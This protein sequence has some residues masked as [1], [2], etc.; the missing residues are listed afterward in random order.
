[1]L[2][3]VGFGVLGLKWLKEILRTA[4]YTILLPPPPAPGIAYPPA[5][6]M[7]A[8]VAEPVEA[9]LARYEKMLAAKAPAAL[10]ALQ[11]AL[12]DAQIDAVES[13]HGFKLTP[14]LRALYRWHNGERASAT[15]VFPDHRFVPLDEAAAARDAVRQQVIGLIVDAAGDGYYYDPSRTEAQGSFFFNFAEDGAYTFYP[16]FRNYLAGVIEGQ[17]KGA[18]GL[19]PGGAKTKDFSK[20]DAVW[21]R[22]G[23]SNAPPAP[24]QGEGGDGDEPE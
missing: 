22:Y 24:Q 23:T 7:P 21:R 13:R 9:L 12:S 8:P 15:E 17:E 6:P 16:A 14:D 10:A 18:F 4:A 19:G 1:V 2:L 20:A 11:P 5:P 3:F